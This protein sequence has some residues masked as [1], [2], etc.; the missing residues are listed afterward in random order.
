M[1]VNTH[2]SKSAAFSVGP[3]N[4][5]PFVCFSAEPPEVGKYLSDGVRTAARS[6]GAAKYV[7]MP[8]FDGPSF[9]HEIEWLIPQEKIGSYYNGNAGYAGDSNKLKNTTVN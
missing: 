5:V 9:L 8:K 7:S 6:L 2:R 1:F 4:A 3:M